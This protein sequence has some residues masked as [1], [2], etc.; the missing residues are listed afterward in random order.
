MTKVTILSMTFVIGQFSLWMQSF[1]PLGKRRSHQYLGG[2][3]CDRR[4]K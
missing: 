3:I 2:A 1:S 4:F